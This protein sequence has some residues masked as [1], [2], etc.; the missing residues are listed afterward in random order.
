M[1]AFIAAVVVAGILA[2]A[3]GTVLNTFFQEKSTDAYARP[4]ARV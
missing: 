3:A 2:V 1:R 4:S